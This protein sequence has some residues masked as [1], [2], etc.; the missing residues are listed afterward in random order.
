[1]NLTSFQIQLCETQG[2]LFE[3]TAREGIDSDE[4]VR[5]FMNS[6]T[7]QHLDRPYDHVQWA[8]K[9]YILEDLEE[10]SGTLSR[11]RRIYHP[12]AMFWMGYVYRYWH[13]YTGESSAE[14]YGHV[15]AK[16]MATIYPGYHTLDCEQT[17]DRI[18]ETRS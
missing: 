4:F 8:G 9:G 11:N 16:T 18:M 10:T 3:L 1:M 13:F 6:E 14:I 15:D 12:E 5:R 2:D 17:I 7:A